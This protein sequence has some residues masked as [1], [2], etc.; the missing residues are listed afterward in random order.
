MHK[1]KLDPISEAA[2]EV[3]AQDKKREML[4]Q[5]EA[6]MKQ[7]AI[8][9]TFEAAG[10]IKAMNFTRAQSDFFMIVTLKQV[11]ESKEYRER[12][13]LTWEDFCEGVG[14]NY[15]TIDRQLADLKPFRKEF[16][17]TLSVFAGVDYS[18]IKY[19]GMSVSDKMSEIRDG[20]IIYQGETIPFT[21]E[22][23][24]EFQ[25]L[26]E[27]LEE[28]Y[29]AQISDKDSE[30]KASNRNKDRLNDEIKKMQRQIDLLEHTVELTDLSPE[31]QEQIDLLKKLEGDIA[32]LLLTV[33][34]KISY[35]TSSGNVLRQL[36][37]LYIFIQKL[38]MEERMN[39]NEIYKDAEEVPW[40]ITEMELPPTN[41]LID[42]LPRSKGMGKSFKEKIDKRKRK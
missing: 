1:N 35:T 16:L 37:F 30:L 22:H 41:V 29:K 7:K 4:K 18:K 14:L 39:L 8:A 42:N 9:F 31:E 34:Q 26:I 38:F 23:A 25:A 19:L 32:K 12:F 6:D 15:K 5:E 21:P 40:E 17:D 3:I 33:K 27:K 28:D 11:K 10:K 20:A 24:D 2:L 36:Y 13:G